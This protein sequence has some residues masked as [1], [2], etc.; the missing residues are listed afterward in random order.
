MTSKPTFF[1]SLLTDLEQA[2]T[3]TSE[4][5][6]STWGSV[7]TFVSEKAD[8]LV[9]LVDSN[10]DENA[11]NPGLQPQ[12]NPLAQGDT[13][14]DQSESEPSDFLDDAQKQLSEMGTWMGKTL[15]ID[16]SDEEKMASR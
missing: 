2:V 4:I 15:G 8:D 13:P 10:D 6:V 12:A 7:L 1:D 11:E 9:G 3:D 5:A 16:S 14:T